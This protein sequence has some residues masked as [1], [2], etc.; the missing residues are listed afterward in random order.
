MCGEQVEKLYN[1]ATN[2]DASS[3]YKLGLKYYKTS[4][5]GMA[6]E[7]FTKASN[8]G[9]RDAKY[10]L[11]G[12]YYAGRGTSKDINKAC[13]LLKEL[14]ISGDKDSFL[15]LYSFAK[16]QNIVYAEQKLDEILSQCK[17][18]DVLL[19]Y[20]NILFYDKKYFDKACDWYEKSARQ[21]NK[22]ALLKLVELSKNGNEKAQQSLVELAKGSNKK[23]L[24]LLEE[25]AKNNRSDI[26]LAF[27]EIYASKE[28]FD[29]AFY[30]YEQSASQ[31]NKDALHKLVKLAKSGNEKAL[32]ILENLA[33]T[34]KS[35][36]KLA[37]GEI[38]SGKGDFDKAFDCFEKAAKQ[39]NK[40]ALQKLVELAKTNNEK[41][42]QILENL[43]NT[44]RSDVQLALGEIYAS[45]KDFDKAFDCF[46]KAAKQGN[47]EALQKLVKL[48][49]SGNEKA[50]H[51]LENLAN[52]NKSNIKLAFGEIYSGKGDFDKAF[53]CFEKAAKQGNKKALQKLVE[54][55]K[56]NN[57]K[58]LQI[59]ENLANTNRSDVQLALGE[60]YA[61]KKDFDKAFDCF[62]KAAKQGNE[63]ALQKLVE[64]AKSNN[65]KAL[66]IL[67]NLANTNRS[68]VQLALG[69]IYASKKDFDKAFDWYEKSAEQGNKKA[70]QKL[71]ELAK[72]DNVKAFPSTF[73]SFLLAKANS[74]FEDKKYEEAIRLYEKAKEEKKL[75]ND[76]K[77]LTF[78]YQRILEA[79]RQI[80]EKKY[81]EVSRTYEK[82]RIQERRSR[83]ID[84]DMVKKIEEQK[85]DSKA[86]DALSNMYRKNSIGHKF[87]ESIE[88]ENK[89]NE[90]S[91]N[92]ANK[93]TDYLQIIELIKSMIL[94]EISPRYIYTVSYIEKYFLTSYKM[95]IENMLTK[96]LLVQT[97]REL[98]QESKIY[99]LVEAEQKSLML[100]KVDSFSDWQLYKEGTGYV[101]K[102]IVNNKSFNSS[103][104]ILHVYESLNTIKHSTMN[105]NTETVTIKTHS[106]TGS[107]I[108]FTAYYC[109]D[110]NEYYTTRQKIES[111]FSIT[112]YPCVHFYFHYKQASLFTK[113]AESVLMKFGYSVRVDGPSTYERHALLSRLITFKILDK[114]DIENF[115]QRLINYNGKRANMEH[116]VEKWES[117][118]EFLK[119]FNI[120]SQR[121]IYIENLKIKYEGRYI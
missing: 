70:F 110:C 40:K 2:G 77:I 47:E 97:C 64:L 105:H 43:A 19:K 99:Y 4:D 108:T 37:F 116:A 25:L 22:E 78:V 8:M 76:M 121:S 104:F 61:S 62:E 84:Q 67:E 26:Q 11:A 45:K 55:A 73:V 31:G 51:I 28:D 35:N 38:Y 98:A 54:L 112:S 65:E 69:E 120:K 111:Y 89:N 13:D 50:L 75:C 107:L 42:L 30:W 32:H 44:N 119:S 21:G 113:Q 27:G 86:K 106:I 96:D 1:M 63:E 80:E 66:H 100:Y 94:T 34:N 9:N 7:Y 118:L 60:I 68:D 92:F 82:A 88:I 90:V 17:D 41:A 114:Y 49:K 12:M 53:D 18:K 20:V 93:A 36:I 16:N 57:E 15:Q 58:A 24:Q 10:Y 117:D 87:Q 14:A 3:N 52:T 46:E 101:P 56:T 5:F 71:I 6:F 109:H 91:M 23:V 83:S 95:D 39:G 85:N 115:I 59:L 74:L 103:D 102:V 72:K 48:A 81:K 33:N 29:K 79:K